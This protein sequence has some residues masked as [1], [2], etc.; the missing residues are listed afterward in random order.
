MFEIIKKLFLSATCAFSFQY[1][2]ASSADVCSYEENLPIMQK[3]GI[4]IDKQCWLQG[5]QLM[6]AGGFGPKEIQAPGKLMQKITNI[7]TK[8]TSIRNHTVYQ[9]ERLE[10]FRKKS[11]SKEA[12]FIEE[13]NGLTLQMFKDNQRS[14]AFLAEYE[15][16]FWRDPNTSIKALT[17]IELSMYQNISQMISALD[18]KLRMLAAHVLK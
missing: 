5:M 11:I 18:D 16:G 9:M 7:R 10:A 13:L 12:P 14:Q 3:A 15:T 8:F 4:K 2:M 6:Q 17:E 1:C